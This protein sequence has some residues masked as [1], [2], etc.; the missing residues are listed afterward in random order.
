MDLSIFEIAVGVFLGGVLFVMFPYGA[1]TANTSKSWDEVPT[2]AIL[3]FVVPLL[4]AAAVIW[5]SDPL[6]V[7]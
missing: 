2:G 4:F 6:S 3:C 7:W 1:V 5:F